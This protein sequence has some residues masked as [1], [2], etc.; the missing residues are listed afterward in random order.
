MIQFLGFDL[1][2]GP[3]SCRQARFRAGLLSALAGQNSQDAM[4]SYGGC[5]KRVDKNRAF[6]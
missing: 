5:G 3:A 2:V 1:D 6:M 4:Q